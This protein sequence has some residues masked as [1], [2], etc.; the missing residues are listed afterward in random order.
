MYQQPRRQVGLLWMVYEHA[1]MQLQLTPLQI[2]NSFQSGGFALR[3]R[4]PDKMEIRQVVE[5]FGRKHLTLTRVP[6][7]SPQS[8]IHRCFMT[9]RFILSQ[10]AFRLFFLSLEYLLEMCGDAY[11]SHRDS[12]IHRWLAASHVEGLVSVLTRGTSGVDSSSRD[13]LPRPPRSWVLRPDDSHIST[14]FVAASMQARTPPSAT[15]QLRSWLRLAK[16]SVLRP[17]HALFMGY[18]ARFLPP[19]TCSY[20]SF[21]PFSFST[22]PSFSSPFPSLWF[23]FS[24]GSFSLRRSRFSF[25]YAPPFFRL[26]AATRE[27]RAIVADVFYARSY[28]ILCPE[29]TFPRDVQSVPWKMGIAGKRTFVRLLPEYPIR[30]IDTRLDIGD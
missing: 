18:I 26:H 23:A 28:R 15:I 10:R 14:S 8:M 19:Y 2:S 30:L 3:F 24:A 1:P 7:W 22:V 11:R 29:E 9:L 25:A 20:A 6:R 13:E 5:L 27:E 16:A 12:W 21:S 4:A 17:Q